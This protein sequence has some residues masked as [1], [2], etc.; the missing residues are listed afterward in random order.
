MRLAALNMDSGMTLDDF[1]QLANPKD[2][3][4]QLFSKQTKRYVELQ[5]RAN[6]ELAELC[7]MYEIFKQIMGQDPK[8]LGEEAGR[9]DRAKP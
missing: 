5:E 6:K 9:I 1:R 4:L 2:R 3:R 8:L 7:E